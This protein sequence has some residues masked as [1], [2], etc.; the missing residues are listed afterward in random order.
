MAIDYSKTIMFEGTHELGELKEENNNL[1]GL[2]TFLVLSIIILGTIV[3]FK[4]IQVDSDIIKV[5]K[6][7]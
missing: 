5:K 3:A 2:N 1:I 6:D 7:L 4:N